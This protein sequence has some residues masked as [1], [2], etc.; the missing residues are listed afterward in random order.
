M[1]TSQRQAILDAKLGKPTTSLSFK[2]FSNK[3]Y[4][5]AEEAR[6]S[7]VY[8]APLFLLACALNI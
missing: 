1:Y 7:F 4:N 2:H 3:D 8:F 5:Q 6:G